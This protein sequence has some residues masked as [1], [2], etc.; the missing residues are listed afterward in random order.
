V[1]KIDGP[2]GRQAMKVITQR[3]VANA[4]SR[5]EEVTRDDNEWIAGDTPIER[6][7]FAALVCEIELGAHE[8]EDWDLV[9]DQPFDKRYPIDRNAASIKIWAQ[10]KI[11]GWFVDFVIGVHGN[12][13]RPSFLVAE[14]DGHDFHET[15]K[16]QARRDRSRDRE[17]QAAGFKIFRFTGSEIWKD[18]CKCAD[19]VLDW[20][21]GEYCF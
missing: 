6:T 19:S 20:A 14:C 10:A 1:S 17:M 11:N 18:P 5:V 3:A 9:R 2:I 13:E 12:K 16:E 15:T 21:V 4:V 8:I 7:L